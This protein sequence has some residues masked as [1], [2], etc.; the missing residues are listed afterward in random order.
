MV[1]LEASMAT[2][3]TSQPGEY[4]ID[5]LAAKAQLPS[6]TIRFYQSRGALM[7]PEIRGRV[8]YYGEAH[9]ERLKLIAQLQDRGLRMDAIRDLVTGIERGE[10]DLAQWLGVEQ[11]VQAPWA[12]D[13]ARLVTEDELGTLVGKP[14]VGLVAELVRAGFLERR[15]DQY[16]L[17]SPALLGIGL[18]L[19]AA[20]VDLGTAIAAARVMQ[21]HMERA[22]REL[23]E[24]FVKGAGDGSVRIDDPVKLLETL[25]PVGLDAVRIVFGRTMEQSLRKLL[26]SGALAAIP[27]LARR[28]DEKRKRRG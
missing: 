15:G 4:T 9:L 5:E 26:E 3:E 28:A 2:T 8:A 14:R 22:V 20:G 7:A 18:R 23:T 17:E 25:R 12:N 16:L 27:K 21:K 6:R 1:Y 13:L 11:Q 19:E 24:L 10:V